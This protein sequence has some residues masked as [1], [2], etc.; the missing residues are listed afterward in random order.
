VARPG[1]A[2][3]FAVADDEDAEWEVPLDE[4]LADTGPQQMVQFYKYGS[5]WS[6]NLLAKAFPVG[7]RIAMR[8]RLTPQRNG[9]Q[10]MHECMHLFICQPACVYQHV[11]AGLT[12]FISSVCY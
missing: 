4:P 1:Q 3:K 5:T 11:V 6:A 2:T 8:G 12:T 9:T 10:R 7:R